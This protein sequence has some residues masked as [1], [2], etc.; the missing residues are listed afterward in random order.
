[1]MT[2]KN[3]AAEFLLSEGN[4]QIS[5]LQIMLAITAVALDAGAVLARKDIGDATVAAKAGGNT[6]N[7]TLTLDA[8]TPELA[9]VMEGI[10]SVRCIEAAANGG[11]FEVKD[12]DG[13]SLGQVAV[14]ATFS[15]HLKFAI[16]DGAT[17]FIVGDGFDITVAA[18]T[19]EYVPYADATADLLPAS[20]IL[21]APAPISAVAQRAVG[22]VRQAEVAADRLVGL[23]DT[24]RV[25]LD[26]RGIVVR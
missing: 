4:G 5:R 3:H 20:A 12:P 22:I 15:D 18:G 8:T 14:G 6:G 16:A 10:Y 26:A 1:M 17:D 2:E 19:G 13:F 25:A 24:A 23:T 21:Y 11:V 9:G 7:G